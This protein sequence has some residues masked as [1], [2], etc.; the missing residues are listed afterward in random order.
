VAHDHRMGIFDIP[1]FSQDGHVSDV[2][3]VTARWSI[4]FERDTSIRPTICPIVKQYNNANQ[5]SQCTVLTGRYLR[6]LSVSPSSCFVVSHFAPDHLP[7]VHMAMAGTRRMIWNNLT[8]RQVIVTST[9]SLSGDVT[10]GSIDSPLSCF[11]TVRDLA[12]DEVSGRVCMLAMEGS[13]VR[14]VVMDII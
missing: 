8:T 5:L 9:F 3:D 1:P 4:D 14:V 13:S 10:F 7:N 12:F 11:E 2:V 6:V